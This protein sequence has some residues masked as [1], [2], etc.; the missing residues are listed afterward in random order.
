MSRVSVRPALALCA[1]VAAGSLSAGE[2]TIRLKEGAGRDVT[3]ARCGTCHSLDYIQMNAPL[4]NE[5]SWEKSMRKMIEKFGAPVD[6]E[7]APRI[8]AYL[9]EYYSSST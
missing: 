9:S 4:M 2:E 7:D 6:K 1:V 3:A 8:L 5:A